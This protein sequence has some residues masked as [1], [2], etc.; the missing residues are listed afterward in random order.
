MDTSID[1]D[2]TMV[3]AQA[4]SKVL[5]CIQN[6]HLNYQIQL[7]PFSA[8][9]SVKKTLV[10]NKLGAPI[11]PQL[12]DS[13]VSMELKESS[14][15]KREYE[16]LLHKYEAASEHICILQKDLKARDITIKE[17][18]VSNKHAAMSSAKDNKDQF[19]ECCIEVKSLQ[20]DIDRLSQQNIK[21]EEQ[22][23]VFS[24][25]STQKD[26]ITNQPRVPQPT[27]QEESLRFTSCKTIC[28][29][30]MTSSMSNEYGREV[31]RAEND[32]CVQNGCQYD[33]CSCFPNAEMS[34]SQVAHWN[35]IIDPPNSFSRAASSTLRSH[36]VRIPNPGEKFYTAKDIFDDMKELLTKQNRDSEDCKQ[37]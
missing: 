34:I 27:L 4:F 14:T 24:N 6:S 23:E 13:S 32:R 19:E 31:V 25:L 2:V 22:L 12:S 10:K 17:L 35:P 26:A 37:S 11:I 28:S 9:I 18:T 36:Y 30:N 15:L 20:N 8:V 3:A 29:S 21:L 5:D 16:D 33:S 7:T 1:S